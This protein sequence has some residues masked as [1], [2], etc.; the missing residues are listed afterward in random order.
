MQIL[1]VFPLGIPEDIPSEI[2]K[3]SPLG[4]SSTLRILKDCP[5]GFLEAFSL[6]IANDIPLEISKI[7]AFGEPYGIYNM[8]P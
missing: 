4:E 8:D 6:G 7:F 2:L 1:T 3:E 5:L